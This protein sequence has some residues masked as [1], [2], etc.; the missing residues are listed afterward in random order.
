LRPARDSPGDA[1]AT[2]MAKF[3]YKRGDRPSGSLNARRSPASPAPLVLVID[4]DE[5]T[6]L[7]LRTI[8]ERRG[9]RVMEAGDGEAGVCAAE[10]LRPDLVFMD[11]SLRRMDGA[12]ATRRIR[13]RE[14]GHRVPLVFISGHAAPASRVEAFA[15]GCDD[16]LVKPID[17]N[18]LYRVLERYLCRERHCVARRN[19]PGLPS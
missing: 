17:F 12:A 13:E 5:D 8:L 6:R 19:E 3:S 10:E 11:G 14:D 15:A 4:D 2:P 9:I 7:M 18:K 1:L 16:Y